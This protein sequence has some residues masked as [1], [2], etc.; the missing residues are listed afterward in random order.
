TDLI[1]SLMGRAALTSVPL[2]TRTKTTPSSLSHNEKISVSI[3]RVPAF[4]GQ[5]S[6]PRSPA[7]WIPAA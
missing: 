4:P 7:L 1:A 3:Q 5:R 2:S 6:S